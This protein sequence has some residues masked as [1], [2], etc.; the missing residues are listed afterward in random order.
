MRGGFK[1][2]SKKMVWEDGAVGVK[3]QERMAGVMGDE[4]WGEAERH[5]WREWLPWWL[6]GSSLLSGSNLE[7]VPL[8]PK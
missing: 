6:G 2:Y 7:S 4:A 8:D 3:S 5:D 1:G